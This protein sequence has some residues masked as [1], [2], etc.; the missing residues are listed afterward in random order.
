MTLT[1]I[2]EEL[3]NQWIVSE[4]NINELKEDESHT[5]SWNLLFC[6]AHRVKEL[7][8]QLDKHI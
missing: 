8:Y 1:H 6:L 5:R 2:S 3:L 4:K 7:Q